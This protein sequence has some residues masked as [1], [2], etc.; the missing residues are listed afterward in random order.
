M[1][2]LLG[3]AGIVHLMILAFL[4]YFLS[5]SLL[6]QAAVS[7]INPQSVNIDNL[8]VKMPGSLRESLNYKV[9]LKRIRNSIADAK[10][11]EDR[12]SAIISLAEFTKEPGLRLWL[13]DELLKEYPSNPECYRIYVNFLRNEADGPSF[14]PADLQR[15]ISLFDQM[16]AYNMWISGINKLYAQK[17]SNDEVV[18]FMAP[19]M[20][21]PPQYREYGRIYQ[22]ISKLAKLL[23]KNETKDKK[24][25]GALAKKTDYAAIA[26]KADAIADDAKK[27]PSFDE[28][29]K[30]R[31][32]AES[33]AKKA[34]AEAKGK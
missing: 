5:E 34:S 7:N 11:D 15:F 8:L 12:V 27:L 23:A 32:K 24:A 30:A 18:S 19:L 14:T 26:K 28:T 29:L 13:Y 2:S 16:K 4:L 31:V 25:E 33:E 20:E 21:T 22:E 6:R 17:A 10:N 3:K 1:K 9:D